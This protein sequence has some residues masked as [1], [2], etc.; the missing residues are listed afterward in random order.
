M[1]SRILGIETSSRRATVA[2]VEDGQ[3]LGW[4]GQDQPQYHAERTLGL[5]EALLA[6]AGWMPSTLDRIAVGIGPGA[7]TGIR[8]G[9]ALAQGLAF[10]L[11]VPLVGVGSLQAMARSVPGYPDSVRCPVV[12]ARRNEVFLAAYDP[13][14]REVV[15][16]LVLPRHSVGELLPRLLPGPRVLLGEV[17][18]EL[19]LTPDYRSP[20]SDLPHA[21]W[22]AVTGGEIPLDGR[23][24]EPAY[25]REPDATLPALAPNPL[26]AEFRTGPDDSFPRKV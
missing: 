20:G 19:A 22:V 8:V 12:D 7:F 23:P 11:G 18:I 3:P 25:V 13:E 2:L 6:E 14:G 4:R 10:G 24:V 9:I 16:P 15:A 26:M 1:S 21:T 5:V 17:L